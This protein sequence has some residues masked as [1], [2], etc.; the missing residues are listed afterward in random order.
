MEIDPVFQCVIELFGVY[1]HFPFSPPKR[2]RRERNPGEEVDC[3]PAPWCCDHK[4]RNPPVRGTY[5]QS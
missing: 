1:I 5:R 4:E 2:D 3:A